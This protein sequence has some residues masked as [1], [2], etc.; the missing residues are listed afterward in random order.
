MTANEFNLTKLT[1]TI[2]E[3]SQ[4]TS[5]GRNSLYNLAN[6]GELPIIKVG[7]RSLFAAV[8]IAAFL[9][10]R[11]SAALVS[12]GKSPQSAPAGTVSDHLK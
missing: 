5:L 1:Y 3:T 6:A 11:R 7:K 12:K 2:S 10:K 9:D 8:D 4:I